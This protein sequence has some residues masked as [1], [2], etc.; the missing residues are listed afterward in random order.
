MEYSFEIMT[1]KQGEKITLSV[2]TFNQRAI[3]VYK[4][5]GFQPVNTFLQ[6]TNGDV[7][8]FMNMVYHCKE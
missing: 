4:N 7:Y 6:K 1:Q 8:E 3:K 2:A 5:I